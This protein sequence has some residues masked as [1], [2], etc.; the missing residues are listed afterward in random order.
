MNPLLQEIYAT[1]CATAS[2]GRKL[3]IAGQSIDQNEAEFLS[4][5]VAEL[6]PVVTLEVGLAFGASALAI[7][8]ALQVTSSNRHIVIDPFQNH[9]KWSGIGLHNLRRAGF[10][11]IIEFH[12]AYSY[13]ILPQLQT[14]GQKID[15]AFIDGAHT[16]DFVFVDFFLH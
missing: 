5:I 7:C 1:N 10:E 16:F 8:D 6:R 9:R 13:T 12:E 14:T 4:E 15:F 11:Q 2:D 3:S